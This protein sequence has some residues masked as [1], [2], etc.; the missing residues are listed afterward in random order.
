MILTSLVAVTALSYALARAYLQGAMRSFARAERALADL[1]SAVRT[2]VEQDVPASVAKI[3]L[4]LSVHAGCGCFVRGML[5]SHYLPRVALVPRAS[6]DVWEAAFA[7]VERLPP[8]QRE[9]FNRVVALVVVY[10]CFRNPLQGW[11]FERLMRSFTRAEPSWS[12]KAEAKLTAW[13]VVSRR[14][15]VRG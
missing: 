6:G 14:A 15:A 1:Q 3:A 11:L 5:T 13:S 8:A 4:Q 2:L 7:D 12:D 10:D 9:A